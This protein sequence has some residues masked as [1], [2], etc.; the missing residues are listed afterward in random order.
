[1][2]L[3][4]L[5]GPPACGKLTVAR[6]LSALTGWRLFH[7][8][9]AIDLVL[10]LFA[11]GTPHFV[12]LRDRVWMAA[13]EE[14]C[15]AGLEAMIFT[16]AQEPSVPADFLARVAALVEGA[17]GEVVFVELSAPLAVLEARIGDP[18]RKPFGKITDLT[19][20]RELW[21][22]DLWSEAAMPASRLRVDTQANGPAQAA[23]LIAEA[24][25]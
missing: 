3:V 10:S 18:S 5:H 9:L 7:N 20:F 17:G 19:L 2:K 25:A 16:Y 4:I 12:T 1:M 14:A 21:A 23:R 22:K 13:F 24:L 15:A 8:H 11:F 6:E